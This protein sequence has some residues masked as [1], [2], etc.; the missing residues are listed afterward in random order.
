MKLLE[1]QIRMSSRSSR[2]GEKKMP[3]FVL[4][5]AGMSSAAGARQPL[6]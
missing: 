5:N 3:I 2:Q 4:V 1:A 6:Q